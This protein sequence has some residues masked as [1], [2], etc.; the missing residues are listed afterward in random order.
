M[1]EF[2][3]WHISLPCPGLRRDVKGIEVV[4]LLTQVVPAS[5]HG[6]GVRTD[7]GQAVS[8]GPV[9]QVPTG[10]EITIFVDHCRVSGLFSICGTTCMV[11]N[12]KYLCVNGRSWA[13]YRKR[14]I[15][16]V[17]AKHCKKRCSLQAHGGEKT[18][19][20]FF[21]HFQFL[22]YQNYILPQKRAIKPPI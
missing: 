3:L 13:V 14:K 17:T 16:C 1:V 10:P 18:R 15:I 6:D 11:K 12:V 22:I 2:F 9:R 5:Q 21:W 4:Q 7:P 20:I 8:G 19:P